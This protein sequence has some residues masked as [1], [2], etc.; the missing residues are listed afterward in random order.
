L[1]ARYADVWNVPTYALDRLEKVVDDLHRACDEV[2]R[3]PSTIRW[4]L[5]AVLALAPDEARYAAVRDRAE[6]RYGGPAFGLEA[7]GFGGTPEVVVERIEELRQRGFS[8]FVFFTWDRGEEETL[9][10]FASEVMPQ[11]SPS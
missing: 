5:E 1:V 7:G 4:S 2:G 11:F 10:C 3:D 6:R 8:H 9:S